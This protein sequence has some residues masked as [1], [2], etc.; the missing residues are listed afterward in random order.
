LGKNTITGY[1]R[2]YRYAQTSKGSMT[3]LVPPEVYQRFVQEML[4]QLGTE[5]EPPP[6][7]WEYQLDVVLRDYPDLARAR[8]PDG[9]LPLRRLLAT[10]MVDSFQTLNRYGA[11]HDILTACAARNLRA[12]R[13]LLEN[14][15]DCIDSRD[16]EG[17]SPLHWAAA[18]GFAELGSD[19]EE[20]VAA[21]V[22]AG[23]E[24]NTKN[25]HGMTALDRV[26]I[27]GCEA[28]AVALLDAGAEINVLF[29]IRSEDYEFLDELF[30][31]DPTAI[32]WRDPRDNQTLLHLAVK[33]DSSQEMVEYLLTHGA[34]DVLEV[35]R[36]LTYGNMT[37]LLSAISMKRYE[38]AEVL[39]RGGAN[40]NACKHDSW[41]S[42][43]DWR[44]SALFDATL[45]DRIGLLELLIEHGANANELSKSGRSLLHLVKSGAAA[46]VLLRAGAKVDIVANCWWSPCW[47]PLDAAIEDGRLE[48]A[49]ILVQQGAKPDFYYHVLIGDLALVSKMLDKAPDLVN[50][51]RY[52]CDED[53]PLT[54]PVLLPDAM[55]V[56][57]GSIGGTALHFACKAGNPNMVELLLKRG[58]DAN[59]TTL[60]G[61]TPLHDAVYFTA[62]HDLRHGDAVIGRLFRAGANIDQRTFGGYTALSLADYLC[63]WE[64]SVAVFDLL[65]DLKRGKQS[66]V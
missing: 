37:P 38:V 26:V 17:N 15:P 30:E 53:E 27:H 40:V 41:Q 59:S 44:C 2:L 63:F 54:P 39:V 11:E 33:W 16:E 51:L 25:C 9:T 66:V 13:R 65:L 49:R 14:D 47:S 62:R 43:Y 10:G 29:G 5:Q 35:P 50:R 28:A 32:H 18:S 22:A 24:V 3:S 4:W 12:V 31:D 60:E 8:M 46:E 58:A 21:L 57:T 55:E 64:R 45:N 23:A 61:W 7:F 42:G 52:H 48:V 20:L 19:P 34:R 1:W 6:D 56:P 36:R